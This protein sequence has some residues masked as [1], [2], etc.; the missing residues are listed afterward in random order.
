[1]GLGDPMFRR[2]RQLGWSALVLFL[3]VACAGDRKTTRT[4]KNPSGVGASPSGAVSYLKSLYARWTGADWERREWVTRVVR[5]LQGGTE[6]LS[7]TELDRLAALPKEQ[8]LDELISQPLFGDFVL[9]FNLFWM[10]FK[11]NR[12]RNFD[13]VLGEGIGFSLD[14]YPQAILSAQETMRDGNHLK[15]FELYPPTYVMPLS[16]IALPTVVGSTGPTPTPIPESEL[17]GLRQRVVQDR[18]NSLRP[19][20]SRLRDPSVNFNVA[21]YCDP[22]VLPRT[23]FFQLQSELNLPFS[24]VFAFTFGDRS[25]TPVVELCSNPASATREQLARSYEATVRAF[26]QLAGQVRDFEKDRYQVSHVSDIKALSITPDTVWGKPSGFRIDQALQ[27]GNSSTNQNRKRAAYILKRF[28]CDDMAAIPV[29]D[30]PGHATGV[31]G[32]NGSCYA[33]H[34]RL[35]PMAGFFKDRGRFLSD[36][37]NKPTI[38]FDDNVTRDRITYQEAW[39]APAGSGR[40]WN[41]GFIRSLAQPR[42]NSYGEHLEDLYDILRTAPEVRRCLVRR[43]VDYLVSSEQ[44]VDTGYMDY[45]I[46]QYDQELQAGTSAKAFKKTLKT[47]LLSETFRVHDP[48]P[49]ECYDRRPG[50]TAIAGVPCRVAGI[51]QKYCV[52]CHGPSS[53]ASAAQIDFTSWV[54][55]ANGEMAFFYEDASGLPL[56]RSQQIAHIADRLNSTDPA[57]RMPVGRVLPVTERHEL[58]LWLERWGRE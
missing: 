4:S 56:S 42:R 14:G 44:T 31:H 51:F 28:M 27:L 18:A 7:T 40:D 1:M 23:S 52:A 33:C 10:G 38:T 36:F 30:I 13:G 45:L 50:A 11:P 22:V 5:V 48:D 58:L 46:E 3:F 32:S 19:F 9:D 6:S 16:R 15:I 39:R 53:S 12:I 43:V 54:A 47:L 21:E 49:E 29:E 55:D 41:I 57:R 25:V 35:D 17:L 24:L 34:Y 20:V 37:S 26:E 2:W 8:V